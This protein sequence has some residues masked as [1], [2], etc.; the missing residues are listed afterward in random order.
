LRDLS[1][2]R[3]PTPGLRRH[4]WPERGSWVS[5]RR[6]Q[7]RFLTLPVENRTC[8]FEGIRLSTCACSPWDDP[9]ASVRI[10]PVPQVSTCGQLARSLG[11]CVSLFSPARGLRPQ[12]SSWCPQLSWAQ[13][14]LPHPTLRA[15][16]GVSLG[17]PLPT[18]HSPS[19][20]SRSLPCAP[21][22]TPTERC[23]WRVSLLAPSALCGSPG[24]AQRGG[25]VGLCDPRNPAIAIAVVFPRIARV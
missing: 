23:R 20:P 13:T 8:P 21:W 9:E 22:K 24:F 2:R 7:C 11:T 4:Q 6:G 5:A 25:Q 1:Q 10:A 3:C 18:S 12:S 15:G 17:S 19:H 16:L 14:P